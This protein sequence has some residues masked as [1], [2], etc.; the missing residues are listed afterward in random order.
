MSNQRLNYHLKSKDKLNK[1]KGGNSNPVIS[2]MDA[3]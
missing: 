3:L 1:S 2:Q